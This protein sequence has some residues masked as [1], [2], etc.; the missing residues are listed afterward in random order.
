MSSA[1]KANDVVAKSGFGEQ[2]NYSRTL[3]VAWLGRIE[4]LPALE[5]QNSLVSAR[6]RDDIGD[7]LLLL[8]HPHVFTLGR[9]ADERF[10]LNPADIPVYRVSRG[11][12]VTYHGPGQLIGYPIVKL[13]G[14][15]RDVIRYLRQLEQ[16]LIEVLAMLGIVAQRRAGLTGVWIGQEKIASIGVGFRRWVSLHGFALNVATDLSF[17]DAIVPCGIAG[18]RMTSI[19]AQ[20]LEATTSESVSQKVA[21]RF[22]AVFGYQRILQA[23]EA[24]L[25]ALDDPAAH[26]GEVRR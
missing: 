26:I 20:G 12:Q 16:V 6:L 24:E 15:E 18:C 4:Y 3:T 7:I 2:V 1:Q 14:A 25:S 11:G 22:A 23:C 17:F 10:V 19:T 13:E 9:G 5:L 21:D 8:E